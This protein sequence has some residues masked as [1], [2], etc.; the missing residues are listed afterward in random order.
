MIPTYTYMQLLRGTIIV[1]N[2]RFKILFEKTPIYLGFCV[3]CRSYSTCSPVRVDTFYQFPPGAKTDRGSKVCPHVHVLGV[4]CV[5][6]IRGLP[7]FSSTAFPSTTV[8]PLSSPTP[9][10]LRRRRYYRCVRVALPTHI[11][12]SCSRRTKRTRNERKGCGRKYMNYC[13][14]CGFQVLDQADA[15]VLSRGGPTISRG[16]GYPYPI[17]RL[18][19]P[20]FHSWTICCC[21][22]IGRQQ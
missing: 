11:L 15:W 14:V 4:R 2:T 19:P 9:D 3:C 1:N 22:Q 7:A 20:I 21:Q 13:D 17:V 8:A 6:H 18:W 10:P 12:A 16:R 5:V